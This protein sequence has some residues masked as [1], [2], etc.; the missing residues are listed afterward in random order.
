M[1]FGQKQMPD[2]RQKALVHLHRTPTQCLS[3]I[4][5]RQQEKAC[6]GNTRSILKF[7]QVTMTQWKAR[8]RTGSQPLQRKQ[9]TQREWESMGDASIP[10][11]CRTGIRI[12]IKPSTEHGLEETASLSLL[13]RQ[14]D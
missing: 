7:Q 3:I 8:R 5:I 13:E 10:L 1:N 14:Y 9:T 4:I 6:F 11:R 12:Q 2:R